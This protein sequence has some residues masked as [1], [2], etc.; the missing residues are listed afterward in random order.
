MNTKQMKG[1]SV[2]GNNSKKHLRIL[3][4]TWSIR[5]GFRVE[6]CTT[7]LHTMGLDGQGIPLPKVKL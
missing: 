6:E 7:M 4:L 2:R 3:Y 5:N 1:V